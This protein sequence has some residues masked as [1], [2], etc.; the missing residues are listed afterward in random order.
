MQVSMLLL[1]LKM[2]MTMLLLLLLMMM[3][4]SSKTIHQ[5]FCDFSIHAE[6]DLLPR[7]QQQQHHCLEHAFVCWQYSRLCCDHS[8]SPPFCPF[9]SCHALANCYWTQ[10]SHADTC[11][12]HLC[13]TPTQ[14]R[15]DTPWSREFDGR[16]DYGICP[17]N[18]FCREVEYPQTICATT[19]S[20][21]QSICHEGISNMEYFDED[22]WANQMMKRKT[23][24]TLTQRMIA[25]PTQTL[26][27]WMVM[28]MMTV[29]KYL[30]VG[31]SLHQI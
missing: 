23:E 14:L 10:A 4:T 17:T 21:S 31:F 26:S 29:M 18:S 22:L 20:P 27:E 19:R 15:I 25:M 2:M 16:A 30:E 5:K 9:L 7:R 24:M 28:T 11:N 8:K 6:A 12:F 3:M 1:L 13:D